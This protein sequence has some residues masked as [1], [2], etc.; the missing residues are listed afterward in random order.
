MFPHLSTEVCQFLDT[1]SPSH[2]FPGPFGV[3]AVRFR[4][5]PLCH[6][7]NNEVFVVHG[8]IPGAGCGV[9]YSV[10]RFALE[11]KA[12]VADLI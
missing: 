12:S 4:A 10:L 8:G 5:T 7:I 9:S 2:P 11:S 6:V 3:W 1:P